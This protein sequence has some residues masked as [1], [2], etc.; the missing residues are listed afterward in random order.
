MAL[1]G[2]ALF[3]A[4]AAV[5]ATASSSVHA[6]PAGVRRRPRSS[7]AR[8]GVPSSP[9]W[10]PIGPRPPGEPEVVAFYGEDATVAGH[11]EDTCTPS[12]WL[13]FPPGTVTTIIMQGW[14]DPWMVA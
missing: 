14:N 4:A 5:T 13:D 6:P 12:F 8:S 10:N 3:C 11:P 7:A 2:L 9:P 1:I